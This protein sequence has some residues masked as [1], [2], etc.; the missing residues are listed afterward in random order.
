MTE[1][2]EKMKKPLSDYFPRLTV[3][4]EL[5]KHRFFPFGICAA[6]ENRA[7]REKATAR[8]RV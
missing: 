3:L 8:R 6:A 1:K 2:K 7:M 4:G 5:C